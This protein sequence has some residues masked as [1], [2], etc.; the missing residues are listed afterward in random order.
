MHPPPQGPQPIPGI[1]VRP[2]LVAPMQGQVV[3]HYETFTPQ[4]GCCKCE[5]MT[6]TGYISV[7]LLVLFFWPLAFLPCVMQ[8]CF[9]PQQRPVFGY[10]PGQNPIPVA[11]P[12][13]GQP[14]YTKAT[15][16]PV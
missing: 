10:G 7:I 1:R 14:V 13:Q 16:P 3:T 11:E 8:E 2:P 4:S 12:V 6:Q 5:G 9:E 15:E